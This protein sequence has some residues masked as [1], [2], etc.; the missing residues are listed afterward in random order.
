MALSK[1]LPKKFPE[2]GLGQRP[3]VLQVTHTLTFNL[4]FYGLRGKRSLCGMAVF[5]SL[6]CEVTLLEFLLTQNT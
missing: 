3:K 2:R 6:E 5:H 4:R 1:R